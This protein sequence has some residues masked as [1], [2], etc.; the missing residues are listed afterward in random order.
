MKSTI[1]AALAIL[2]F[3]PPA[4]QPSYTGT[5]A[6]KTPSG[7][8]ITITL[9]QDAQGHATGAMSGGGQTF[10][11]DARLQDRNLVGK[12]GA[13]YFEA[14]L[15][16]GNIEVV[17]ADMGP[18]GPDLQNARNLTF[19]RTSANAATSPSA[20]PAPAARS[21]NPLGASS[22]NPLASGR[23]DPMLGTFLNDQIAFTVIKG[24]A[25]PYAGNMQI[26]G[27]DYPFTATQSAGKLTGSFNAGG[28]TYRFSA[29]LAGNTLTL[30]SDN[31]TYT[32]QRRNADNAA[33]AAQAAP[34]APQSQP[35][36]DANDPQ[37][38]QL[39]RL[40]TATNW[41]TFSYNATSG[42]TSSS[43]S[44]FRPDGWVVIASNSEGGTT[45]SMGGT[46]VNGGSFYSQQQGGGQAQWQVKGGQL[47]LN[48]GQGWQIMP[49]QFT[50]NPNGSVIIKANGTEYSQC[51]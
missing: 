43:K 42:H 22:G 44:T 6:M 41:C 12:A 26:G 48:A 25:T 14:V 27:Q 19:E 1:L 51:N 7:G 40:L 28:Q 30:L 46:T 29:T 11:I 13:V 8:V 10:A 37:S 39:T 33:A 38:Q 4:Q 23:A 20:A 31:Q 47:Y 2:A 18:N 9:K 5:Y 16:G 34:G 35:Q 45:N 17:L 21:G 50:Q 3:V 32:L 15:E 24:Q 36:Q 49:L